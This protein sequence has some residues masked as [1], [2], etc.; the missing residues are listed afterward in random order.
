MDEAAGL[1]GEHD[2]GDVGP[3]RADHSVT[4]ALD[5]AQRDSISRYSDSRDFRSRHRHQS[6][7]LP[8][9]GRAPS[10]LQQERYI[11]LTLVTV[12]RPDIR[13]TLRSTHVIRPY[14]ARRTSGRRATTGACVGSNAPVAKPW[15]Q[16]RLRP[17][18]GTP[19]RPGARGRD[20]WKSCAARRAGPGTDPR[21]LAAAPWRGA[22][23]LR[24]GYRPRDAAR[25][26]PRACGTT[27]EG[28]VVT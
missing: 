8:E 13:S 18:A 12:G 14:S 9:P 21:V 1:L 11:S 20:H 4:F 16:R 28:S 7:N 2:Q 15:L 24:D 25:L 17:V 10:P 22:V 26:S 3:P 27:P 6:R 19:R 5:A 23:R